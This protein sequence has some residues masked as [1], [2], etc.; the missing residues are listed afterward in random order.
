MLTSRLNILR[1]LAILSGLYLAYE[2]IDAVR[3]NHDRLHLA[4]YISAMTVFGVM[5][6][7]AWRGSTWAGLIA[8]LC[9]LTIFVPITSLDHS[10]MVMALLDSPRRVAFYICS[11]VLASIAWILLPMVMHR[12]TIRSTRTQP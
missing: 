5:S 10:F 7:Q 12:L 8:A 3:W 4:L 9:T 11:T 1:A 2:W 6:F